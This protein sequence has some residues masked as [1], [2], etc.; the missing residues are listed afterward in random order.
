V[1]VTYGG[2]QYVAVATYGDYNRFMTS[3]DCITWTGY[4]GNYSSLWTG[5]TYGKNQFVAVY[6]QYQQSM[7]S[8]DGVSWISHKTP[9][10]GKK[11]AYGNGLFVS[12]GSIFAKD[13]VV[14]SSDGVSWTQRS[15]PM[16]DLLGII[17]ASGQFVAVGSN[18]VMTSPDGLSWT[19]R[20]DEPGLTW[21]TYGEGLYVAI[22]SNG[23]I[24]TSPDG[25][26]WT[27]RKGAT[28][29]SAQRW[30]SIT[31]GAGKFVAVAYFDPRYYGEPP[32]KIVMTSL[33]GIT[34]KIYDAP[35]S[36]RWSDLSAH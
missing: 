6:P 15:S 12:V 9:K 16:T 20:D 32:A 22:A 34:W 27:K 26:T 4:Q 31:Y 24:I 5:I 1:S 17:Y 35:T 14:T 28:Q 23:S 30:L 36:L 33:D 7:T 25:I 29:E 18:G 2:G 10:V 19:V 3:P 21:L 11:V 8:P 13:S